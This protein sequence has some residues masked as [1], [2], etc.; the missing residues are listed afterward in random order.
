M[1][2]GTP[3]VQHDKFS[4]LVE[5]DGIVHAKFMKAT[6][7]K[8]TVETIKYR[9]GGELFPNVSPGLADFEPVTLERGAALDSDLFVWFSTVAESVTNRGLPVP[10]FARPMDII[11]LDRAGIEMERWRL[12]GAFPTSFTTGDWDTVSE[13][14]IE[15]VELAFQQLIYLPQANPLA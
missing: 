2:L 6:G 11:Q 9:E 5:I 14:R 3:R 4:F 7:L 15:V 12:L 8:A 13:K 1:A 10:A